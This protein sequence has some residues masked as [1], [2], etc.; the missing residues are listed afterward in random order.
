MVDRIREQDR[1]PFFVRDLLRDP[2]QPFL[3]QHP[4]CGE[5]GCVR[6]QNRRMSMGVVSGGGVCVSVTDFWYGEV[7][8]G[9]EDVLDDARWHGGYCRSEG[10][11]QKVV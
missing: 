9:L 8:G 1:A 3:G 5:P 10:V 6:I 4:D 7:L 11:D 2:V